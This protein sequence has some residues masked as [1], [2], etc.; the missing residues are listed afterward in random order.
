RMDLR[1]RDELRTGGFVGR[2]LCL[3][4]VTSRPVAGPFPAC[5]TFQHLFNEQMLAPGGTLADDLIRTDV[6]L[7]SA[8]EDLE[9]MQAFAQ[10][11]NKLIRCYKYLQKGFEEEVK[12]LLLFLKGFSESERNM[13]ALLTGILLA[14]GNLSASILNSLYNE[15]LVTESVS[16]AF[17]VKLFQ[18]WINEKVITAVAGSLGKVNMDNKINGTISCQKAETFR[19]CA[20][21]ANHRSQKRPPQIAT[22]HDIS[23]YVKEDM[24]KINISEQTKIQEYCDDNIHSMKYFQKIVVLFY[25]AEVLSEEPILKCY[26]DSHVAKGKVFFWSK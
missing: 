20:E 23:M 22:R 5:H 10:V 8:Q 26:K 21:P 18:S 13:L 25:E 14:K 15:N 3:F 2:G 19:V 6:C 12:Q 1:E 24:K 7:F 4:L 16:A 9:T 17:A 11:F